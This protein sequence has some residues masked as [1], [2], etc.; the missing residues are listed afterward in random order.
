MFKLVG[1]VVI[2]SFLSP[3]HIN[4]VVK[5]WLR[6]GLVDGSRALN[7]K[8]HPLLAVVS[9]AVASQLNICVTKILNF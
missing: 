9:A 6:V 2:P 8:L 7:G 3:K 4:K 1:K 5:D